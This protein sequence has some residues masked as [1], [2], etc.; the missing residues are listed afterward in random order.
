MNANIQNLVCCLIFFST[1]RGIKGDFVNNGEQDNIASGPRSFWDEHNFEESVI[2]EQDESEDDEDFDDYR[3]RKSSVENLNLYKEF[4][5]AQLKVN[6]SNEMALRSKSRERR[7]DSVDVLECLQ[8]YG[9]NSGINISIADENCYSGINVSSVECGTDVTR[10]HQECFIELHPLYIKRGCYDP[11]KLNVTFYCKCTLCNDKPGEKREYFVYEN[12][13]DWSFDN[14]RLQQPNLP[15]VITACKYCNTTGAGY[16]QT[17]LDG[18]SVEY[19]ICDEG[20]M[21]FTQID[22]TKGS[23]SRGCADKPAYNSFFTFCNQSYCNDKNYWD[24]NVAFQFGK[25]R[26]RTH[27]VSKLSVTLTGSNTG[28]RPIVNEIL[29]FVPTYMS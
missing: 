13:K 1:F 23:I 22:K 2:R 20:Q 7:D 10:N 5:E 8:C 27:M 9:S 19:T 21:C 11:L 12:I 29:L 18:T 14:R 3:L 15:G 28:L 17:C 26:N 6:K 16:F 25:P 24:S 4:L